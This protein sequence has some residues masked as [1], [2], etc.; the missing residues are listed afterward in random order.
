MSE[1]I[2][3][4][5]PGP[6]EHPCMI[7]AVAWSAC[8]LTVALAAARIVLKIADPVPADA[9]DPL[10][11]G[12]PLA[13]FDGSIILGLTALGTVVAL[14][15]P[16]NTVGWILSAIPVFLGLLLLGHHVFESIIAAHPE[17]SRGAEL[18]GWTLNWI[19]IP[20]IVPALT[21]FPLLFPSG[22]LLT[23][24][25]RVVAWLAVVS[26]VA[27][28]VGIAFAPGKLEDPP[29]ENPLGTGG[30]LGT[31]TEVLGVIGFALMIAAALASATSL[32]LRFRRSHGDERQQLK[33]IA[34][35][36]ALF[37]VIFLFPTDPLAGEDAGFAS[38]LL[39]LVIVEAAVAVSMLR[40]R[41]Y[42]IDFVINRTLV[43]GALT[44]ILAG[45]YLGGV[46]LLQLVLSPSSDLAIAGSTLT[47]AALFRPARAR[48]QTT[49]DRRFF[50][51]KY[52]G[53]RT[54]DQFAARLREQVSL[55]ALDRELRAVV[56]D[57]MQPAHVSLWLRG[58]R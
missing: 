48:V 28:F 34:A 38:L 42:D 43:Y 52:D 23:P 20:F 24:R 35:G 45:T 25:W 53:Q 31:A 11:G 54:L 50:R 32:V 46:L 18:V 8:G 12:V 26:A 7:R 49:V 17:G 40:Y 47:V 22:R 37:V 55:D 58:V 57:T 39:G 36:A 19:W 56:T 3:P 2:L 1:A 29:I 27:M 6:C 41:L 13:V 5:P 9:D 33:W 16:R 10:G 21:L 51:A 4:M 30:P 44:S 15:H 14:K